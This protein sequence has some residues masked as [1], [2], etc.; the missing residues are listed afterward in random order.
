MFQK[1]SSAATS[2]LQATP[3]NPPPLTSYLEFAQKARGIRQQTRFWA[4]YLVTSTRTTGLDGK[5]YEGNENMSSAEKERHVDCFMASLKKQYGHKI[6]DFAFPKED[7]KL[8]KDRG[9]C[10]H[11]IILALKAAREQV[12]QE[13]PKITLTESQVTEETGWDVVNYEK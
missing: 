5:L 9:L 7:Q 13:A 10:D 8:A 1:I 12:A 3:D 4:G 11:N 6:A 2:F